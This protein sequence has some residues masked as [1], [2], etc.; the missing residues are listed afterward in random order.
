[1]I[2][3]IDQLNWIENK[4]APSHWCLYTN[5]IPWKKW[6]EKFINN[7]ICII[8]RRKFYLYCHSLKALH[9]LFL[10]YLEEIKL[11]GIVNWI[12]HVSEFWR[13]VIYISE[14][15]LLEYSLN[16]SF[17]FHCFHILNNYYS[18]IYQLWSVF[19]NLFLAAQKESEH[20]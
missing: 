2:F 9:V 18:T 14:I 11:I 13:L 12:F 1:M 3:V 20:L 4:I 17:L 7:V 5:L 19:N 10:T 15:I 6:L 8:I 16:D